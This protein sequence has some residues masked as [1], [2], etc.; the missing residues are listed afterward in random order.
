MEE[1]ELTFSTE[2]SPGGHLPPAVVRERL[3][4]V[5]GVLG[6]DL[7]DRVADCGL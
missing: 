5:P 2:G 4:G 6:V 1:D 3:G 7:F